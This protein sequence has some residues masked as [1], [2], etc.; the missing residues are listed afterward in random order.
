MGVDWV[1]M[2]S[3]FSCGKL[4]MNWWGICKELKVLE[5]M[6]RPTLD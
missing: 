5:I 2:D 4:L 1:E 3:K 6:R